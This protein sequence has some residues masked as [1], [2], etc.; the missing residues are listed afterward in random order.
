GV[1]RAGTRGRCWVPVH[2]P[3]PLAGQ[4]TLTPVSK[5]PGKAM[6]PTSARMR[7]MRVPPMM[8]SERDERSQGCRRGD[9]GGPQAG[10]PRRPGGRPAPIETADRAIVHFHRP[11]CWLARAGRAIMPTALVNEPDPDGHP[12]WKVEPMTRPL[13][14]TLAV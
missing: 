6:E 12:S 10:G 9:S 14:A 1:V 7:W 4:E 3:G 13:A 5:T 2:R 11:G 8:A